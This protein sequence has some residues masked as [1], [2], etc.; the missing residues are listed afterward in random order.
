MQCEPFVEQS[1]GL[2]VFGRMQDQ[3]FQNPTTCDVP[4]ALREITYFVSEREFRMDVSSSGIRAE[5][6]VDESSDLLPTSEQSL[7]DLHR[8]DQGWAL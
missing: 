5:Q 2:I 6:N 8:G 1:R 4:P 3:E 7:L